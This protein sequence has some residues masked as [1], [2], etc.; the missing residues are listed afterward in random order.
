MVKI[1]GTGRTILFCFFYFFSI[2]TWS[3]MFGELEKICKTI[4][5]TK[6]HINFLTQCL[7]GKLIPKGFISKRRLNTLKSIQLE[8]RFARIRMT[9][10]R[11]YLHGKLSILENK[12]KDITNRIHADLFKKHHQSRALIQ[13]TSPLTL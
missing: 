1:P 8:N 10:Q 13:M 7:K 3:G 11:K 12:E 9:E 5:S 2:F 4:G 6:A